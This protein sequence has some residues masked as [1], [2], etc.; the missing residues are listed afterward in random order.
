MFPTTNIWS[1][2]LTLV[3]QTSTE[4]S[5]MNRQGAGRAINTF[6]IPIRAE[7]CLSILKTPRNALGPTQLLVK[8]FAEFTSGDKAAEA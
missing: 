2:H 1:N 8:L 3:G 5:V 7:M 6:S 4:N